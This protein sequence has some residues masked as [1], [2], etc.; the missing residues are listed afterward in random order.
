M[1][2]YFTSYHRSC[3]LKFIVEHFFRMHDS[4][5]RRN[6]NEICALLG[7][8]ATQMV[9]PYQR[10]A[11]TYASPIDPSRWDPIA[12]PETSVRNYQSTLREVP[13]ECKSNFFCILSLISFLPILQPSNIFI[14]FP[15]LSL[16]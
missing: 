14:S 2:I 6:V 3:P 9:I 4:S 1:Y 8:Y 11:T 12:C 13:Q 15:H 10:F 7:F 5:F 16:P